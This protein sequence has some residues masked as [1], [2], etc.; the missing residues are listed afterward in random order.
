MQ[1]IV[2]L[3]FTE[4]ELIATVQCAQDMLYIKRILNG[5]GLKVKTPMI[6]ECD[7]KGAVDLSNNWS[8]GGRTR[9]VDTREYFLR[10]LKEANILKVI[11]IPGKAND[12]DL[13]TK[14]L[15][16][17]LFNKHTEKYCGKDK[18]SRNYKLKE[19]VNDR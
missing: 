13:F 15:G 11:W 16:G 5:I 14:N 12:T 9:H 1:R 19:G 3:S 8:T 7:N 4:A 18:Y 2:A 6:L 10:E 17:P